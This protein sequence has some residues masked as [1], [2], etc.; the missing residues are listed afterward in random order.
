MRRPRVLALVPMLA[1]LVLAAP[2]AAPAPTG[3]LPFT[4]VP[5]LALLGAGVALLGVG[6][7]KLAADRR[8]QAQRVSA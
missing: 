8:R 4:G 2:A 3:A 1:A 6:L 5:L 7:A